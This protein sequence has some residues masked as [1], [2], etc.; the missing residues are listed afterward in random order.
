MLY[1]SDYDW[2]TPGSVRACQDCLSNYGAVNSQL[3]PMDWTDR[4][5]LKVFTKYGW[6]L[7]CQQEQERV[8]LIQL[9]FN[10]VLQASFK[11]TIS[12][13]I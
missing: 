1:H 12:L 6:F 10:T 13:I 8:K 11:V 7:A 2:E 5:L 4:A 3:W 9:M